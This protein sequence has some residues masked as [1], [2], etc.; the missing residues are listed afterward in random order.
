MCLMSTFF[1]IYIISKY[2]NLKIWVI[3]NKNGR[4]FVNKSSFTNITDKTKD[5]RNDEYNNSIW[6]SSNLLKRS[7]VKDKNFQFQGSL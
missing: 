6:D 4:G 1:L 3:V 7:N 5:S 2:G